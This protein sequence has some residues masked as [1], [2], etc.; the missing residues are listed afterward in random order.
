MIMDQHFLIIPIII[1][2][3][4]VHIMHAMSPEPLVS[5]WIKPSRHHRSAPHS[6]FA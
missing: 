1:V 6:S 3:I 5:A 4:V 2:F